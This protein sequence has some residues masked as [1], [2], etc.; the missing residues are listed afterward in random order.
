[1]TNSVSE[2]GYATVQFQAVVF[3]GGLPLS[4]L[5][6]WASALGLL[7]GAIAISLR[8]IIKGAQDRDPTP[9]ACVVF[10]QLLFFL[11]FNTVCGMQYM[12]CVFATGAPDD[13]MWYLSLAQSIGPLVGN[14][15]LCVFSL[16]LVSLAARRLPV[17]QVGTIFTIGVVLLDVAVFLMWTTHVVLMRR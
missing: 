11:L 14:I 13:G 4:F 3:D 6:S 8:W 10:V 1:M 5:L 9:F 2:A 17:L 16:A 15:L 12:T 7:I